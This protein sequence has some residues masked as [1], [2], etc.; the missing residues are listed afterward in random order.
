[1]V[2]VAEVN[3]VGVDSCDV[4]G[5]FGAV[6]GEGPGNQVM[7]VPALGAGLRDVVELATVEQNK[8]RTLESS[9]YRVCL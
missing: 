5:V 6:T 2:L 4:I 8:K 9:A 7:A 3:G 1:M